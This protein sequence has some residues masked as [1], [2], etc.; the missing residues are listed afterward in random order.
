VDTYEHLKAQQPGRFKDDLAYGIS[1]NQADKPQEALTVLDKVLTPSVV[2]FEQKAIAYEK[3]N[4]LPAA[5]ENYQKALNLAP[6][7]KSDL[8]LKMADLSVSMNQPDKA[9]EDLQAYLKL[10]PANSKVAKS[11]GDLLLSQKDYAGAE[12]NY[13][14]ALQ[15]QPDAPTLRSLGYADQMQ[16]KLDQAEAAYQKALALEDNH[17]TRLN[18]ALIYHQEKKYPQALELYRKLIVEDPSSQS[19]RKDMGQVM[20]ALADKAYQDKDYTTALNTYQDAFMLGSVPETAL[21]V[22]MANTQYALKNTP[23]AY[24]MYQRVLEKD[25]DNQVAR[26]NKAQIDI[27]QKNY[28]SALENL[29]WV[30]E[31][32]P[33]TLEAYRLLAFTHAQL[34]D[35]G[36]AIINY[37]KALELQPHDPALLMGY[38]NAWRETGNLDRA[39]QAY[40]LATTE[41]PNDAMIQYNL[42]SIYNLKGNLDASIS[43]YKKALVLNPAFIESYYGLGT[44]LE[45]KH[46]TSEA[47]ANYET[48]IQKAPPNSSYVPLAKARVD[49]LK[50]SLAAKTTSTPK[51]KLSQKPAVKKQ[52]PVIIGE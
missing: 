14:L 5:S 2:L 42:G 13:E 35:Y 46:Q 16:G 24:S 40:E 6:G 17:Q 33:D 11:L 43:S 31:K 8:Y 37:K 41:S 18:L 52:A 10:H 21:L 25:P 34:G 39:Q 28:M 12:T 7:Q 1:L 3:L 9:K 30:V 49:Y 22:G 29:R 47:I 50:K 32:H 45:K 38:G 26:L 44:T 15:K 27:D 51:A 48:F 4:N 23:M 20:L 36:Q 19:L